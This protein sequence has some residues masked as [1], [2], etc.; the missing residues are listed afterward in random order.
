ML[1]ADEF[2]K[3]M[4]IMYEGWTHENIASELGLSAGF[5]GMLLAGTRAPSKKVLTAMGFEKI[6]SYRKAAQAR[7]E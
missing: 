7:H 2:R 4:R 1:T 6:T 5:V 3:Y